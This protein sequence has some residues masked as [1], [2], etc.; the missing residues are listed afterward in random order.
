MCAS[1]SE[2]PKPKEHMEKTVIKLIK[3]FNE[4]V[5]HSHLSTVGFIYVVLT[6]LQCT[7]EIYSLTLAA[8]KEW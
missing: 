8:L 4:G 5:S 3:Q 7:G 1:I 6:K 2:V